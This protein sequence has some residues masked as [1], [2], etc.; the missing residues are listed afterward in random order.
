MRATLLLTL[1][2]GPTLAAPPEVVV[3]K[4]VERE[5]IDHADFSG[6]TDASTTVEIRSRVAGTLDK[7]LF[8]EGAAVKK[9]DALFQLDD[10]LQRAEVDK[11]QAEVKRTEARLKV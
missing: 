9:G 1:L 5:V 7:V 4:P 2:T 11:A 8:K 6:R 10:R 3:V